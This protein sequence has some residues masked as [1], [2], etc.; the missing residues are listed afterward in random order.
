MV[1]KQLVPRGWSATSKRTIRQTPPSQKQLANRI[2]I[3]ALKNTR[4]T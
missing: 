2:K 4:R 1:R 3:M